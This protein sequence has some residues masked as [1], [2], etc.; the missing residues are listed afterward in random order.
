MLDLIIFKT[1]DADVYFIV[2]RMF[3]Y[4]YDILSFHFYKMPKPL[5]GVLLTLFIHL[6]S[7]YA[8]FTNCSA[9]CYIRHRILS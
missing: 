3:H 7:V 1:S 5:T 9:F 2:N 8:R 4:F 6:H